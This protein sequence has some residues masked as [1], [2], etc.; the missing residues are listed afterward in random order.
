MFKTNSKT[1]QWR[2]C[3]YSACLHCWIWRITCP[4]W[5][6]SIQW[7]PN[8]HEKVAGERQLYCFNYISSLAIFQNIAKSK[9]KIW[10]L[11]PVNGNKVWYKVRLNE[12]FWRKYSHILEILQTMT[13]KHMKDRLFHIYPFMNTLNWCTEERLLII[14]GLWLQHQRKIKKVS[15]DLLSF[16]KMDVFRD[17]LQCSHLL[18]RKF[19]PIGFSDDFSG[20]RSSSIL[21]NSLYITGEIWSLSLWIGLL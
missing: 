12:M 17:H 10:H 13:G 5:N 2:P 11:S 21:L 8:R 6:H 16:D 1:L 19:K 4:V 15:T 20:N 18:L 3:P 14:K 7:P 9:K